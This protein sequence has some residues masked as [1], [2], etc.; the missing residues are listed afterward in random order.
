[1]AFTLFMLGTG[2]NFS[3]KDAKNYYKKTETLSDCALR[4]L[5]ENKYLTDT[6]IEYRNENVAVINGPSTL[7]TEV[8]NRITLGVDVILEAM[9]RGEYEINLIGHSR[10]AEEA[11]LIAH[12]LKRIK[13]FFQENRVPNNNIANREETDCVETKKEMDRLGILNAYSDITSDKYKTVKAAFE[14]IKLPIFNI[15]PVPGGRILALPG[16]RWESNRFYEIPDIVAYYEQVVCRHEHTVMFKPTIPHVTCPSEIYSVPGHHG[17][18][19]GNLLS[20]DYETDPGNVEHVQELLAVKLIRF[21]YEH[22][23]KFNTYEEGKDDVFAHLTSQLLT[24]ETVNSPEEFTKKANVLLLAIYEKIVENKKNYKVF[25][26]TTYPVLWSEKSETNRRIVHHLKG[27]NN[28]SLSDVLPRKFGGKFITKEHA[29]LATKKE[30]GLLEAPNSLPEMIDFAAKQ[31]EAICNNQQTDVKNC[32]VKTTPEV[33]HLLT[34][35]AGK[36]TFFEAV[37]TLINAVSQP[38][39]QGQFQNNAE[40]RLATYNALVSAFG[41]LREYVQNNSSNTTAM[42][43]LDKWNEGLNNTLESKLAFFEQEK[44]ALLNRSQGLVIQDL[45]K[46]FDEA[47]ESSKTL[48]HVTEDN[49][50]DFY[51]TQFKSQ[52][53]ER[54]NQNPKEIRVFLEQQYNF[55]LTTPF[56]DTEYTNTCR[57]KIMC[58]IEQSIEKITS[59]DISNLRNEKHNLLN[60]IDAFIDEFDNFKALNARLSYEEWTIQLTAIKTQMNEQLYDVDSSEN[61]III[62]EQ[63]PDEK[64]VLEQQNQSLRDVLETQ[65]ATLQDK[66]KSLQTKEQRIVELNG[67]VTQKDEII[68]RNE[69]ELTMQTAHLEVQEQLNVELNAELVRQMARINEQELGV[70]SLHKK[71]ANYPQEEF[72]TTL[73]STRLRPLTKDYLIH[74]YN[75]LHPKN[76]LKKEMSDQAILKRINQANIPENADQLLHAKLTQ[77][78]AL[79]TI[80]TPTEAENPHL[81][82]SDRI[83]HFYKELRAHQTAITIH[84]NPIGDAFL[85]AVIAVGILVSGVLPGLGVLALVTAISGKSFNF[86]ESGGQTFFNK[87]EQVKPQLCKSEVHAPEERI[88]FT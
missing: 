8:Y 76:K 27:S 7:G 61:I 3:M 5:Y 13:Q 19:S 29:L 14:K 51:I 70:A 80:L 65:T 17:T 66:E 4:I 32:A 84:R 64:E 16:I 36:K 11:T 57:I 24:P 72:C 1:M 53:V 59:C 73:V 20:Q 18:P 58:L 81:N 41:L 85:T 25:K 49:I 63:K 28:S 55:F 83:T 60:S 86:W 12:E 30:L 75:A 31:I 79:Y 33:K 74:L 47:F 54:Q 40:D 71:I 56:P 69:Q 42:E 43:I 50:L 10:G 21:L 2:T 26:N 48:E 78:S 35:D 6:V 52:L 77:I 37:T 87:A 67:V 62:E 34:T 23:V 88:A 38:Y 44:M 46:S 82:Y 9:S 15:D 39:L 22:G 45:D 68:Q